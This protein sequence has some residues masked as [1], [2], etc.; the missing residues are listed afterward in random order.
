MK[1]PSSPMTDEGIASRQISAREAQLARA[2]AVAHIGSWHLDIATGELEWSEETCRIFGVSPGSRM[3]YDDFLSALHPED[4]EKVDAAWQRAMQGHP[5]DLEHRIVVAGKVKWLRELAELEFT[6]DG[7]L[8]AGVGT[9]QDITARKQAEIALAQERQF[10]KSL[11][12]TIPDLIWLKDPEGRYL[13]CNPRFASLYGHPEQDIIG[14]TDLDFV[15]AE[16]AGFFRTND[17]AAIE[18]GQPTT[19]EE[20]LTF[21]DS[22]RELCETTKTPMFGLF[23]KCGWNRA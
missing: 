17:L 6:V 4:R 12:N 18:A 7:K 9:V 8:C 2:Q 15:D 5:Y 19:N 23:A 11:L 3:T 16:L 22:H 13:A 14:R 21:A 20:W 10:L 1:P